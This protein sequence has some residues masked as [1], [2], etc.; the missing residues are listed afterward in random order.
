MAQIINLP[1]RS[2]QRAALHVVTDQ[3]A[4]PKRPEQ[5]LGRRDLLE[6]AAVK[7]YA[8]QKL[9]DAVRIACAAYGAAKVVE[10][11]QITANG[12]KIVAEREA[13]G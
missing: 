13:R 7:R 4:A 3:T 10:Q 2:A 12:L 11:L 1:T 5:T 9:S 8:A 6:D